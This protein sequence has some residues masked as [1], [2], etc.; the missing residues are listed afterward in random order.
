[1]LCSD[2]VC[3][4]ISD[5]QI[6]ELLQTEDLTIAVTNII[7]AVLDAGAPDNITLIVA[8]VIEEKISTDAVVIGAAADEGNHKRLPGIGFPKEAQFIVSQTPSHQRK[9]N[10]LAPVLLTA[11][12][13]LVLVA[14]AFWWLSNQWFVGALSNSQVIGVYQ[15]VPV[16]GLNRLVDP[17]KIEVSSLPEFERAQVIATVDAR[18]HEDGLAVLDRLQARV[19]SCLAEPSTAGCPV[20]N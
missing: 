1:M 20:M 3:G 10:W 11:A 2:G 4:V 6:A 7:D 13:F 14:G 19:A 15:G 9:R 17:S 16:A 8:D 18:T 12:T 5:D